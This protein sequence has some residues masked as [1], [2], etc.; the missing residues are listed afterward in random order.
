MAYDRA[1]E[2]PPT[3]RGGNRYAWSTVQRS[4]FSTLPLAPCSQAAVQLSEAILLVTA[5][6]PQPET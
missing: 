4:L 6:E 1:S 3:E 2:A 5:R